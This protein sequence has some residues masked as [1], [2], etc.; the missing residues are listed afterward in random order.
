MRSLVATFVITWLV[1]EKTCAKIM[2]S[3][4]CHRVHLDGDG[5]KLKCLA[6]SWSLTIWN[7]RS[8]QTD[9]MFCIFHYFVFNV[10]VFIEWVLHYFFSKWKYRTI[11]KIHLKFHH[12]SSYMIMMMIQ[13]NASHLYALSTEVATYF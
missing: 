10:F 13:I 2:N 4:Y 5:Q 8:T 12:I 11:F 3:T 7:E 6:C 1:S 9:K